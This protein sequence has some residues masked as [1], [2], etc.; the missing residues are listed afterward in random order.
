MIAISIERE[1]K[2]REGKG[3]GSCENFLSFFAVDLNSAA[4]EVVIVKI[5]LLAA[6]LKFRKNKTGKGNRRNL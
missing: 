4:V 6:F 5:Y 3:V 1:G 2:G